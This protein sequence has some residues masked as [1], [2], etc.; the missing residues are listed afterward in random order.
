MQDDNKNKQFTVPGSQMDVSCCQFFL[1]F[2]FLL[3]MQSFEAS[4][5]AGVTGPRWVTAEGGFVKWEHE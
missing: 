1:L 5:S 2:F 3:K 4:I